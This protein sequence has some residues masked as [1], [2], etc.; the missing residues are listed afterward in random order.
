MS[1]VVDTPTPAAAPPAPPAI[2]VGTPETAPDV[3]GIVVT[4]PSIAREDDDIDM[5]DYRAALAERDG[6]PAPAAD[7][8]AADPV[9]GIDPAPTAVAAPDPAAANPAPP[10]PVRTPMLPKPRVDEM[11]ARA[12][13]EGR[14]EALS[15]VIQTGHAPARAAA[16]P[17]ANVDPTRPIP[18]E[19]EITATTAQARLDQIDTEKLAL[20]KRFD[21]GE[22]GMTEFKT[23]EVALDREARQ[24]MTRINLSLAPRQQAANPDNDLVL[25]TETTRLETAHPFVTAIPATDEAAWNLIQSRAH[26]S[27]QAQNIVLPTT[28][29]G[30]LTPRGLLLLRTEM[31]KQTDILGPTLTGKTREQLTGKAPAATVPPT[32]PPALTPQQLATRNALARA[33]AHPV[34]IA[35][36]GH[37]AGPSTM[38]TEADIN[39]MSQ[40]QIEALPA[41]QRR[42][43]LNLPP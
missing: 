34:D 43:F 30:E 41:A 5:R 23:A 10:K 38:P 11:L 2:V 33:A 19:A 4:E 31:A 29:A 36:M 35:S 3:T 12:R 8:P 28:S 15:E 1:T 24:H 17:P 40:E 26:Q 20:S 32:S 9:P 22:I 42:A 18:G 6:P 14:A 27:L 13:A 25:D 39:A 37:A 16:P 7:T 21:D